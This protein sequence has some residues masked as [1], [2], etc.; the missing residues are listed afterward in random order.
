M[1]KLRWPRE[2]VGGPLRVVVILA[3]A[4]QALN[5]WQ[6]S[7]ALGVLP[8]VLAVGVTAAFLLHPRWPTACLAVVATCLTA[9][10]LVPVLRDGFE[11]VAPT[12]Y[13]SYLASAYATPRLRPVWLVWLLAGTAYV[14]ATNSAI[15]QAGENTPQGWFVPFVVTGSAWL[16]LG[17]FWMLG[18]Q[19][20]RRRS[21]LHA[22][23]EKAELAGVMERTRIAREM[24]DIVA[25]NLSGVIALADGARFAAAKNPQVAVETLG[26]ISETSR[27]ALTQM[28]GLLSVL[29]D[30]A[31]REVQATP[32]VTEL[33]GLI[34]DARRSGLDVEVTGLD[35]LPENL[36]TLHQFTLY[37]VIQ[38]MLTNMLRHASTPHG[39]I[40]IDT[41]GRDIRVTGRNPATTTAGTE[42][43]H[44]LVGMRERVRA[45]G[46]KLRNS[47]AGGVFTVTAEVPA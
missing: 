13:A 32:G 30:D 18:G 3:F 14:A 16:G 1:K 44:G 15:V 37:R 28:R 36:P 12:L 9:A 40:T 6:V 46:G 10:A 41:S 8:V 22:L 31:G 21:D 27:E 45:H 20:R 17:F 42:G 19:T 47:L 35:T 4:A 25:H 24:H 23:R 26:T 33:Q 34:D 7:D 29:R 11:V 5:A 2:W 38:E 39:T 43:G